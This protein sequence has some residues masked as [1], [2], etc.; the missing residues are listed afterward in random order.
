VGAGLGV[1]ALGIGLVLGLRG[2][3]EVPAT[4]PG[5][6]LSGRAPDIS[7]LSPRQR[8]DRLFDRVEGYAAR[9]DTA[10]M[11]Q[12]ADHALA[13]YT[14]LPEVDPEARYRAGLLHLRVGSYGAARALAD[15]ILAVDPNHRLGLELRAAAAR[16]GAVR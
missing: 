1:V 2:T 3:R 16:A 5:P 10:L 15:S 8:F 4:D 11:L 12:F 9:G 14:Q 7:G 13:A 6:V